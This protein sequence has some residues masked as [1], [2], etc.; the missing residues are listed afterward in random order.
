MKA[1]TRDQ[2]PVL[3]CSELVAALVAVT[4][5]TRTARDTLSLSRLVCT[6]IM[7]RLWFTAKTFWVTE[8]HIQY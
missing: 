8:S 2:R 7:P 1:N 4:L 6:V 3:V 5:T